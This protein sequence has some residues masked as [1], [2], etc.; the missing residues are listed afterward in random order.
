MGWGGV[1][2]EPKGQQEPQN[3]QHQE[4]TGPSGW[5]GVT[6]AAASVGRQRPRPNLGGNALGVPV[7]AGTVVLVLG[8]RGE[9][10]VTQGGFGNGVGDPSGV[11]GGAG[12]DAG[13]AGQTAGL[14]PAYNPRQ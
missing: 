9:L 14:P 6:G 8:E 5:V 11:S 12:V 2:A 7:P 10:G 1:S 3:Q 13:T 4:V